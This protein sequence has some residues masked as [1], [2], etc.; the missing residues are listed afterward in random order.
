MCHSKTIL[1]IWWYKQND[2]FPDNIQFEICVDNNLEYYW[3]IDNVSYNEAWSL[4][5]RISCI[6]SFDDVIFQKG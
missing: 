2:E 4:Y 5:E 1:Y 6:H 3:N